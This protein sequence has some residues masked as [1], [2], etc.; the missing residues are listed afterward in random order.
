M[1][2]IDRWRLKAVTAAVFPWVLLTLVSPWLEGNVP[3]FHAYGIFA[4]IGLWKL[5]VVWKRER[6]W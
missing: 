5:V 6:Y 2:I 3:G 1:L 4:V